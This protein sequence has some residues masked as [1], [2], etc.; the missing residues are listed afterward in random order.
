MDEKI[1]SLVTAAINLTVSILSLITW[2]ET[3]DKNKKG[4]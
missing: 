3:K 1:I 4:R 2:A